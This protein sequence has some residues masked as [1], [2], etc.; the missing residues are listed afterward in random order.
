MTDDTETI[1]VF[2]TFLNNIQSETLPY[3]HLQE[4]TARKYRSKV[5]IMT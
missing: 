2:K 3:K 5:Y 4:N 1:L